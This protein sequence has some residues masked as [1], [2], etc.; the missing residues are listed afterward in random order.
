MS[1]RQ[2]QK[3]TEQIEQKVLPNGDRAFSGTLEK[4]AELIWK[5]D[6]QHYREMAREYRF[7]NA[8]LPHLE[9]KYGG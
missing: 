7:L 8:F 5:Q 9:T 6:P 2:L 4:L 3:R 1:T